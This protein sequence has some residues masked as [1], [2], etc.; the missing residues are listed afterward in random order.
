MTLLF[1]ST[2][3]IDDS[4]TDIE[5]TRGQYLMTRVPFSQPSRKLVIKSFEAQ[6][7]ALGFS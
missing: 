3:H 4:A 5:N 6:L 7:H 1:N 2:L